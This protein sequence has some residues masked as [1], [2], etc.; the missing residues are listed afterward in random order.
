M[1]ENGRV[2]ELASKAR[3]FLERNSWDNITGEFEELL[4]EVIKEKQT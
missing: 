4:E 3:A 2:E 1:I